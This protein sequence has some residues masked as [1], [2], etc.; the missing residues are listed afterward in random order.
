MLSVLLAQRQF[1]PGKLEEADAMTII[2]F[3]NE[4]LGACSSNVTLEP[5]SQ[6]LVVTETYESGYLTF[7]SYQWVLPRRVGSTLQVNGGALGA[8]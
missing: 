8:G 4:F 7:L 3:Q 6:S 1:V 5:A 2:R